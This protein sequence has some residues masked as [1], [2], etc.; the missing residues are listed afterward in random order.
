MNS[1]D[2]QDLP[3]E[4][5]EE[6]QRPQ[7]ERADRLNGLA[8]HIAKLRD[9]AVAARKESGIEATWHDCEEAY[10]G[11]DDLT[12]SDFTGAKWA[13]PMTMEGGLIKKTNKDP[14]LTQAVR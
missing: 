7:K 6:I 9:E 14:T 2:L 5:R 4:V 11:I 12:R 1:A 13:K 8:T 10:L 3:D